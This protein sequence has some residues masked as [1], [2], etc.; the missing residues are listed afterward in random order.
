M[1][2][3]W[4]KRVREIPRFLVRPGEAAYKWTPRAA[5]VDS[6][7]V[8]FESLLGRR[9]RAWSC[10]FAVTACD[11]PQWLIVHHLCSY[12]L[13]D[14]AH[15]SGRGVIERQKR[16]ILPEVWQE[17]GARLLA[18]LPYPATLQNARVKMHDKEHRLIICITHMRLTVI[19]DIDLPGHERIF[20]LPQH[21]RA[22]ST[23]H[24]AKLVRVVPV[25]RLRIARR[26][27][28]IA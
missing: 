15:E 9:S 28:R 27:G 25:Q 17:R 7:P 26:E 13:Q 4:Q 12:V 2:R 5:G 22:G 24:K 20:S 1:N 8:R 23:H 21:D 10:L 16:A 11:I 3:F 18:H 19:D 6:V 14:R